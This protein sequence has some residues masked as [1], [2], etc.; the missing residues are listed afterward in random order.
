MQG[1]VLW[2]EVDEIAVFKADL[3][4]CDLICME[5]IIRGKNQIFDVNE[6]VVG[7]GEM[8]ERLKQALP[9]S[10]QDWEAAVVMPPFARNPTVIYER[11]DTDAGPH[12]EGD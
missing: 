8:A 5:F 12:F 1:G 11:S 4:T 2:R 9:C 7:F 6:E 10:R 3:I